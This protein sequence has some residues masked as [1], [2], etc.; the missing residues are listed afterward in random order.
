[1]ADLKEIQINGVVYNF[2]DTTARTQVGTGTPT[3][4]DLVAGMVDTTKPYLYVGEETGYT[5]G[6]WYFYDGTEWVS[7]GTYGTDGGVNT[8]ARNILKYILQRVAYTEQGMQTYVDALY[9][10]LAQ[11]GGGSVTTTYMIMNALTHVTNSNDATGIDEGESYTATLTADTDYSIDSVVITMGGTDITSTAYSNGEINIA[12]VTGDVIITAT[13]IYYPTISFFIGC[14]A[15]VQD[16]S[17][18]VNTV[19]YKRAMAYL[20]SQ[21]NGGK[22]YTI[23]AGVV[24]IGLTDD[25]YPLYIP[26]GATKI[27]VSCPDL[28]CAINVH[29]D[30]NDV[31]TG[32]DGGSWSAV[33]GVTDYDLSSYIAQGATHLSIGFKNG[34]NTSLEGT[35]ID[36]TTV[37]IRFDN[38]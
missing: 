1:M 35:T 2:K 14:N 25:V 11:A 34:S 38:Y 33:G 4:V 31:V 28:S 21:Y 3:I 16:S 7:G 8:N 15:Q 6:D 29:K 23:A 13:A 22:I 24:A 20:T 17:M 26:D 36:N 30:E 10:A 32:I 12:S 5:A 18:K 27:T 37:T 19:D 9:Q